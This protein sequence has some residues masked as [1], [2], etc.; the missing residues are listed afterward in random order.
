M[1]PDMA[2]VA[3]VLLWISH[4]CSALSHLSTEA[5]W[6]GVELTRE[7]SSPVKFGT[8]TK[9]KGA[10]GGEERERLE[11]QGCSR[12]LNFVVQNEVAH[13]TINRYCVMSQGGIQV[14]VHSVCGVEWYVYGL[15]RVRT[16]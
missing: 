10:A 4:V 1:V 13:Y 6:G 5:P 7:E 8:K 12:T 9:K 15:N 2:C 14:R 11:R 3:A 16:L